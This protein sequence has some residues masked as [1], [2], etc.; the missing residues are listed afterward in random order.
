MGEFFRFIFIIFWCHVLRGEL[1]TAD[2]AGT[3]VCVDRRLDISSFD[4]LHG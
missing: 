3:E 4:S 2:S 1:V